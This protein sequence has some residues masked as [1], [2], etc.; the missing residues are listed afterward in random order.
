M[1]RFR[2]VKEV[3]RV[4]AP[5]L[6]LNHLRDFLDWLVFALLGF[7]CSRNYALAATTLFI[8]FTCEG[9]L[10]SLWQLNKVAWG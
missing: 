7:L 9:L 3:L 10:N 1:C 2:N 5:V 4:A 8:P 6:I